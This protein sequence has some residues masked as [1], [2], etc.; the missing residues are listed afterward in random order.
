MSGFISPRPLN[1]VNLGG[2]NSSNIVIIVY[3]DTGVSLRRY[4][5]FEPSINGIIFLHS[6]ISIWLINTLWNFSFAIP[7]RITV[8]PFFVHSKNLYF[9]EIIFLNLGYGR[10]LF[11]RISSRRYGS[12]AWL[13]D[14]FSSSTA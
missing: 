6:D 11:T 10:F 1:L 12:I 3:N 2:L 4:S 7:E 14:T 9:L 13:N 5:C 8:S